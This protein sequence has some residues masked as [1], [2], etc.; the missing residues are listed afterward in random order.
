MIGAIKRALEKAGLPSVREPPDLD[1]GYGSRPDGITV[2]PL[3]GGRSLD[4]GCTCGD[5]FVEVTFIGQQWELAG[6]QTMPMSASVVNTLRL[7]KHISLSQWQSKLW[8]CIVGPLE[9]SWRA[10]DHRLVEAT[11]EPREANWF[12]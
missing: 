1:R 10:I 12:C 4:W 3:S 7:Q 8:G 2:F 6:L 9:S 5:T 11:E